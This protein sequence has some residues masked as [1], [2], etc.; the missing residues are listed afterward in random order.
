[1]FDKLLKK[2]LKVLIFLKQLVSFVFVCKQL[3][4]LTM[5]GNY[6]TDV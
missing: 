5:F 6:T 4:I 3:Y 1:M 2:R